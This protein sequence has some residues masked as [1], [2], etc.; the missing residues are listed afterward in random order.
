MKQY[1]GRRAG[2]PTT[3]SREAILNAAVSLLAEGGE[4]ALSFRKLAERLGLSAPSLYTY[5]PNKQALLLAISES[6]LQLS[7][8]PD[9]S[10][11]AVSALR[12]MLDDLRNR[13]LEK[14]HLMFLFNVA[15][16]VVP[17]ME[18]IGDIANIIEGAGI[19]RTEAMLHGQSLL[20]MTLG[21][22]IFETNSE[23]PEVVNL[24]SGLG[25]YTEMLSHLDIENHQRLWQL[26]LER[27]LLF[28]E[29]GKALLKK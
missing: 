17:M 28:L 18:L 9:M 6:V 14:Q 29:Q 22:V 15:M 16:P 24:F 26:S 2:R 19:D 8:A 23:Y 4:A 20:W 7:S 10:Q 5:F 21:F 3:T 1:S 27:N 12:K 25:R 13:L 11:G